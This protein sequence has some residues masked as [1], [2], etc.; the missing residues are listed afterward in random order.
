MSGVFGK[1]TDILEEKVEFEKN[2]PGLPRGKFVR[3]KVHV[4]QTTDGQFQITATLT[5]VEGLPKYPLPSEVQ[6]ESLAGDF[7][8]L[9]DREIGIYWTQ[10][11]SQ[12]TKLGSFGWFQRSLS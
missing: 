9:V 8:G 6:M 3:F 1:K 11:T 7:F 5:K 10:A 12:N 2:F 4:A